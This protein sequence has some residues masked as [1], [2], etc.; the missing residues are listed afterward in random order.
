MASEVVTRD[1]FSSAPGDEGFARMFE[2]LR[3][4]EQAGDD[5]PAPR[6][7]LVGPEPD[8]VVEVPEEMY[9]ILRRVAEAMQQGLAVQITP[10]AHTLTTQQAADLLGISRP[11]LVKLLD[12]GSVPFERIGTHRRLQLAD[13][14]AYREKRRQRQYDALAATAS[15]VDDE[16]LDVV[17]ADLKRTRSTLAAQ[18]RRSRTTT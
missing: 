6:Y 11:T 16:E 12:R 8:D 15:S 7:R 9:R 4:H 17:L 18:R 1:T 3:A 14:L 5:R 2:F 10:R 13:V